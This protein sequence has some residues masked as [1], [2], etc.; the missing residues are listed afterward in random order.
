MAKWQKTL[1]RVKIED[2]GA[3]IFSINLTSTRCYRLM[4]AIIVYN[5]KEN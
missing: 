1:F 3:K 5:L 2:K 4:Q